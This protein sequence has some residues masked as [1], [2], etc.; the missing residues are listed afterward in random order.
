MFQDFAD[1]N[2]RHLTPARIADLR[3]RFDA[4]GIDGLVVPRADQYQ[5]EY[6]PACA[7]RLNWLTGFSGSAGSAVFLKSTAA[8][9]IDG[10]YTLQVREQIDLDLITAL[11]VPAES[12]H[13]WVRQNISKGGKLGFDPWLLTVRDADL[14]DKAC[15]QA[16][17]ELV[18]LDSNPIDAIW[19]DR[20]AAPAK[21]VIQQPLQFAGVSGT[22][23]LRSVAEGLQQREATACVLTQTDAVAWIFNIRGSDIPHTPAVLAFAIVH[24]D[25]SADLFL[26]PARIDE[27]ARDALVRANVRLSPPEQMTEV[28]QALGTAA[29]RVEL[30]FPWAAEALKRALETS[31][32]TVIHNESPCTLPRATKNR[33]ELEGA[34]AAH[35]RDGVPMARFLRWMND[36]ARAGK[37]DEISAAQKLEALRTQTGE[38]RDLSFDT[39]SGAG[40][41]AAIPHYRVS[42]TS[43]LPVEM[44]RIYLVDSGAQYVDGT[45]D[46]TRTIIIGTPTDEMKDRFTRVLRGMIN[47]SRTRFPTGTTGGQLDPI[48]RAPLWEAGLDFDHG[49]G[50]GV[51]SYLSVHEGPQRFSK[52]DRTVLQPGM[53]MSNE[54]GYYKAGEYGIRIENLLVVREAKTIDGGERPM[55][56]FETLTFTPIDRNLVE[57]AIMTDAELAWLND[58]HVQVVKKIAPRLDG[59]EDRAW[60]ETACAPISR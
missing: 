6:V 40:P 53:I 36:T 56:W 8:I 39:I 14:F 19:K 13:A 25:A 49:T 28:L 57:P 42:E 58:Y 46:I 24:D 38:L 22:D 21:P 12:P 33:A 11:Q 7:D 30:D 32:A 37:L 54:P 23:K 31:G 2:Q 50:H 5:G 15:R 55:H 9:F 3:A 41:H 16:G 4:L 18:A 20:P 34:R 51:G 29:A 17:A 27:D 43:N 52:A 35:L 48:A 1:T 44:D 45:T 10:R 26:D 47:L 60:L 59:D